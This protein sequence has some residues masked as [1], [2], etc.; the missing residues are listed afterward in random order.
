MKRVIRTL[1]PAVVPL[2]LFVPSASR[3]TARS[4]AP[5]SARAAARGDVARVKMRGFAFHPATITIS[6]GD[7]VKWKNRDTVTHTS[8]G[9]SWDSGRMAP[10]DVFRHRFRRSGTF[11]YRCTIHSGMNGTVIV[12]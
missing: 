12:R 4:D 6:R 1:V 9:S 5:V 2:L 10:G 11:D 3:A 7:V 8:T